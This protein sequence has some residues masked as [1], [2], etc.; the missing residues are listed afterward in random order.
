MVADRISEC[1]SLEG[2][3]EY[4]GTSKAEAAEYLAGFI[5][6]VVKKGWDNLI[7]KITKP[8]LPNQNGNFTIKEN[9]FLDNEMDET[10]KDISLYCRA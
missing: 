7:N 5:E 1:S 8:I 10:L 6:F 3:A 2:L 9:I 4:I